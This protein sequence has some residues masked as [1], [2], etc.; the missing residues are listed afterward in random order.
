MFK[1]FKSEWRRNELSVKTK[2]K[3]LIVFIALSAL[4]LARSTIFNAIFDSAWWQSVA[5]PTGRLVG[6]QFSA[7]GAFIN[8]LY[9]SWYYLLLFIA[10][11]SSFWL[12]VGFQNERTARRHRKINNLGRY[13]D[14]NFKV[15]KE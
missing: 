13:N 3:A 5:F 9:F 7:V 2:F 8:A 11:M 4:A 12:V 6:P 15:D 10:A 14:K 1:N